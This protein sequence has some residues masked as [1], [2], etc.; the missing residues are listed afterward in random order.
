[1][2]ASIII[3]VLG[4]GVAFYLYMKRTDIPVWLGKKF[5]FTYELLW[6]KYYIDEIYDFIIV[7]PV[8]WVARAVIVNITDGKIIEGIVNGVPRAI[9]DF[10]Q[11]LRRIQTGFVHHYA[12]AMAL[13]IMAIV[14]IVFV[15]SGGN[16]SLQ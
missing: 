4:I 10:S 16:G 14:V 12:T 7:K 5:Q 13:G 9:G 6:N 11:Q 2:A 8:I 15:W 1:M 3:A